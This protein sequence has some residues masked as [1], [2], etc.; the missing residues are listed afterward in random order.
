MLFTGRYMKKKIF[1]LIFSLISSFCFC[2][3][4][5]ISFSAGVISGVP[6]YSS[7]TLKEINSSLTGGVRIICG[8]DVYIN[9]NPNEFTTFFAGLDLLSD[10]NN[11]TPYYSNHLS[12]D[13]P[14]G[15]K[16]YPKLAGLCFGLGYNLGFRTDYYNTAEC[17]K[18]TEQAAWGNGFKFLVEYDFSH[19]GKRFL[20]AIGLYWKYMPR[21]NNTYDNQ[22]CAY[23]N[24]NI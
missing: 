5:L 16:I 1:V 6:V 18:Y 9:L 14:F 23:I 24:T 20:P 7:E 19:S 8:T 17:G 22:I 15:I 2:Q 4:K 10:F 11:L 21:G 13:F 12:L 3:K